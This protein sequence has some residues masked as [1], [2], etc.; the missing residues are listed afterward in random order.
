M[1][2]P[3]IF[4]IGFVLGF[5]AGIIWFLN[6]GLPRFHNA[7]AD[8]VDDYCGCVAEKGAESERGRPYTSLVRPEPFRVILIL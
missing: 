4:A 5:F 8:S 2:Y 7:G 1:I 3:A 6:Y